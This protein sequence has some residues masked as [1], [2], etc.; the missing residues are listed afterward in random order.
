[1]ERY[2]NNPVVKRIDIPEI[3]PHLNDVTSVF[4]PGAIKF[5]DKILLMLR[6]QNRA[7]ET[8]FVMA[9]SKDGLQ[10]NV[11]DKIILWQGIETVNETIFH[12]YDPRITKLEDVYYIMF[13]MDM[14]SGCH[15]GL[16]KTIDFKLFEFVGVVSNE[17]NRNGVLFP[18]K[19]SGKYLRLDRPNLV[20]LED[21]PITGSRIWL[22]Q[23]DDLI[24]WE[25][26]SQIIEGLPHY[27][28]EL[29]C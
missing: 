2:L 16:G 11:E 14:E 3:L 28:D 17:D 27:W 4:N 8:F 9:E 21:G 13:A 20:Q 7:R 25:P 24:K 10:F 18:E 22:S 26:V 29:R 6:V 15:L 12:V 1:M 23:S 5:E 19:I